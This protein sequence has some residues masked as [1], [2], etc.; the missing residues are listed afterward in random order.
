MV[1]KVEEII[2]NNKAKTLDRL[3]FQK[4]FDFR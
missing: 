1:T 3:R 4:K 2:G